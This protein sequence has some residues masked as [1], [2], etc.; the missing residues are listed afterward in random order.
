MVV[1]CSY[2]LTA[3][4]SHDGD[5][6]AFPDF[7]VDALEHMERRAVVIGLVDVFQSD[8][9]VRE[10]WFGRRVRSGSG[11]SFRAGRVEFSVK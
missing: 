7:E 1:R 5:H 2:V 11:R 4:R 8:H 6:L 9:T 3:R 10:H